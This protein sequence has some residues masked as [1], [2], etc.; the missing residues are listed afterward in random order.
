MI[1]VVP[2]STRRVSPASQAERRER[3]VERRGIARLHVG[4][5]RHVIGDHQEVV[6]ERLAELGRARQRLRARA[7]PEIDEVDPDTHD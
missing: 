7:R 3:I 6:A 1:T 4:R 5:D 2:S